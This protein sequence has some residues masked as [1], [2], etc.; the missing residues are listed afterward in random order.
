MTSPYRTPE[1]PERR[2]V[3]LEPG[4]IL[5]REYARWHWHSF[6]FQLWEWEDAPKIMGR[7][8]PV[9]YAVGPDSVLGPA[10]SM[11]KL[12]NALLEESEHATVFVYKGTDFFGALRPD[13]WL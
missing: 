10:P 13:L 2:I 4:S 6:N 11:M 7:A 3:E 1:Y 9:F 12:I 8:H 5:P